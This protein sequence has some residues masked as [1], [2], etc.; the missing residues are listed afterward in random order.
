MRENLEQVKEKL[1]SLDDP[2]FDQATQVRTL[3]GLMALASMLL[4]WIRLDGYSET[5]NGAQ[6][7][8]RRFVR[9]FPFAAGSSSP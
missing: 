6:I 4:P 9:H 5:M 2:N 3:V 1:K 8:D 7:S